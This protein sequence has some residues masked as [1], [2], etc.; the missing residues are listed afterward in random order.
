MIISKTPFR[1]SFCGGSTDLKE[2]YQ[3]KPGAVIS[4]AINK[5]MYITV[6]RKFDNQIRISYSK[7]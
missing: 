3:H 6:N 5:Y 4:T 2:F 7:T 1:I